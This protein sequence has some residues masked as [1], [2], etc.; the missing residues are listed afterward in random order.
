MYDVKGAAAAIR[1]TDLPHE[2]AADI[3][4]GWAPRRVAAP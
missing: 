4:T 2:F 1:Q 3:E